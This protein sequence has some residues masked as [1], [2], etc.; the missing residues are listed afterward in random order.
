[1]TSSQTLTKYTTKLLDEEAVRL[2]TKS[3][4]QLHGATLALH[5]GLEAL[6]G[7]IEA[8]DAKPLKPVL[9]IVPGRNEPYNL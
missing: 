2:L 8:R 9:Y 7:R 4:R 1:M 3:A 6:A 5:S